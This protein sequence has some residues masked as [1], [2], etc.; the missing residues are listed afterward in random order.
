MDKGQLKTG[1]ITVGVALTALTAWISVRYCRDISRQWKRISTDSRIAQTPSGPIEYA[2]A[3][4]G[5]PALVVHGAGGGFDQ[6]M[7]LAQELTRRNIKVIAMSRFGYLRTPLP[8][9]AS[10]EAQADAHLHLMDVLGISRAAIIGASAGAPSAMQFAIRHPD[11]TTALVLMVPAAYHPDSTSPMKTPRGNSLLVDTALRS[12]LLFWLVAHL[13]PGSL[14]G[15]ILATP[16]DV[17]RNA[18][19]SEQQRAQQVMEHILPIS[20]RRLGLLNDMRVTTALPRY[21]LE[22]I[23]VPTLI[24]SL[25]DDGY[26]TWAGA[27]YSAEHIADARFIGYDQ[28]GHLWVGHHRELLGEVARFCQENE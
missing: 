28:G 3:G 9:N 2:T 6:G 4:N 14:T 1:A 15:S 20:P 5:V 8:E 18:E 11:R 19:P 27:R 7:E 10:A 22:S 12:D 26:G 23:Q 24:V 17:V 21:D 25:K 13:A 16:P